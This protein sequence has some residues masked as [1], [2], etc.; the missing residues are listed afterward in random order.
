MVSGQVRWVVKPEEL[1]PAYSVMCEITTRTLTE[2]E[3]RVGRWAGAQHTMEIE[4]RQGACVHVRWLNKALSPQVQED[5]FIAKLLLADT[6]KEVPVG[7][8]LALVCEDAEEISTL[9]VDNDMPHAAMQ[10][11]PSACSERFGRRLKAIEH[12]HPTIY[13]PGVSQA[14]AS[15]LY[16]R[17][18]HVILL[19]YAAPSSSGMLVVHG[20]SKMLKSNS[21]DKSHA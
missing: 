8:P 15:G 12:S 16:F 1:V 2:Q 13:L 4:V 20:T 17:A 10:T 19:L 11:N 3:Y 9:Q 21:C 7:T 5:L 14:C 6:L 18:L